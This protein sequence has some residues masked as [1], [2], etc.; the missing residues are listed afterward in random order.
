VKPEAFSFGWRSPFMSA[1]HDQATADDTLFIAAML[2]AVVGMVA[3]RSKL[4][5]R[6]LA[7]ALACGVVL[8]GASG[9]VASVGPSGMLQ[10]VRFGLP[11]FYGSHEQGV[12]LRAADIVWSYFALDVAV[13][14]ACALLAVS[15]RNRASSPTTP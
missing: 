1:W 11:H 5:V 4:G 10:R 3:S 12:P 15:V 7:I 13:W 8:T 2:V 14:S 6:E 9:L